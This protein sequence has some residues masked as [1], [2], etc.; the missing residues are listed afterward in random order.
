MIE[1]IFLYIDKNWYYL[2]RKRKRN[3]N[4]LLF[5]YI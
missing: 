3:V 5:K 2:L 1:C 4:T